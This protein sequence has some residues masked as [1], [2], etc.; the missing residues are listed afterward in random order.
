MTHGDTHLWIVDYVCLVHVNKSWLQPKKQ[1]DQILDMATP[2]VSTQHLLTQQRTSFGL[3]ALT[4]AEK[5][6]YPPGKHPC[7][8]INL[9]IHQA[10]LGDS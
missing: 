9:W 5:E 8:S 2:V 3:E 7:I 1:W 10:R 4:N 6:C